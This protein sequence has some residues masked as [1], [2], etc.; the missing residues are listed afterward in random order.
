MGGG[1]S[2]LPSLMDYDVTKHWAGDLFDQDTFYALRDENGMVD[3]EMVEGLIPLSD[4]DDAYTSNATLKGIAVK[5]DVALVDGPWLVNLYLN[6]GILPCRQEL[7]YEALSTP[8]KST[9]IQC[10]LSSFHGLGYRRS[11]PTRTAF[12][13]RGL[14]VFSTFT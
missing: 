12:I 11:I 1:L 9:T 4:K 10:R 8:R 3:K 13:S 5:G 2:S 6:G 7:P 14:Q